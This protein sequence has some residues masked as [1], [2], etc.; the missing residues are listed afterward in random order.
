MTTV[1]C[2]GLCYCD[3]LVPLFI[4]GPQYA[5]TSSGDGATGGGGGGG[6]ATGGGLPALGA[7]RPS[8]GMFPPCGG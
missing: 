5:A 6:G 8:Y 4:K 3:V 7:H 2:V 1:V